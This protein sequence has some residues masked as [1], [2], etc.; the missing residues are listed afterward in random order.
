MNDLVAGHV[1]S[2]FTTL[3]T[4]SS[5]LDRVR[6]LAVASE[7]RLPTRTSIPTFREGGIDLVVE[8]W[9]GVLAPAGL[10][11]EIASRLT[12]DLKAVL[13][14]GRVRGAPRAIGRHGVPCLAR[15][16]PRPDR[17]RHG[18]LGRDRQVGRDQRPVTDAAS[19]GHL[20][21]SR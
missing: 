4:A 20:F 11:P 18:A 14:F 13:N 9:W 2:G 16:V 1:Q 7:T 6:A 17:E 19:S 5:V 15:A 21:R 10:P 8:H 3:A 12:S